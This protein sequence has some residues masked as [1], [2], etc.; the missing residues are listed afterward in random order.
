MN[1]SVVIHNFAPVLLL[2]GAPEAQS[3]QS[4]FSSSS[5]EQGE[6]P[7]A[8]ATA[9]RK[10]RKRISVARKLFG[11]G[12]TSNTIHRS[13]ENLTKPKFPNLEFQDLNFSIGKMISVPT[14]TSTESVHTCT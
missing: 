11:S 10:T 6:P 12:E 2:G 8:A 1:V 3:D 5:L 13:F 4:S 9:A 7:T 14:A